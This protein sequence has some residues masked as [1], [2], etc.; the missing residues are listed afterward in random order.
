[1]NIQLILLSA[2]SHPLIDIDG[3]VF[4]QAA[5]FL[6]V[7]LA[8][9]K[10]VVRPYLAI[11]E[12]QERNIGGARKEAE[13]F[14]RDAAEKLERYETSIRTARS[15][16]AAERAEIRKQGESEAQRV[17]TNAREETE[18]TLSTAR[19]KIRKSAPAAQLALRTRADHLAKL[20]AGKVLGRS[21]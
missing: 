12:E 2:Q 21:I 3:T 8:L 20:I 13:T 10:L 5:I 9:S 7:L 15:H 19:E 17:L 14:S 11:L 6:I 1:M 4:L 16:A 18:R